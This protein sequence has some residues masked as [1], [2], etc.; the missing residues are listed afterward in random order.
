MQPYDYG[1]IMLLALSPSDLLQDVYLSVQSVE[2][3]SSGAPS[4][5]A[6]SDFAVSVLAGSDLASGLLS[7]LIGSILAL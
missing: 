3:R 4:D 6:A 5:F 2:R 1:A 7:D